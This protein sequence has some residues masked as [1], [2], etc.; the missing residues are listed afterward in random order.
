MLSNLGF[1][2]T[3]F[4]LPNMFS[5]RPLMGAT[6]DEVVTAATFRFKE[7]MSFMLD[8]EM[9]PPTDVIEIRRGPLIT[10]VRLTP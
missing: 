9:Q 6:Q 4:N 3:A 10:F 2:Q 5:G 1:W 8:G 7:P